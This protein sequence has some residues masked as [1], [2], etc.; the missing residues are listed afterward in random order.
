MGGSDLPRLVHLAGIARASASCASLSAAHSS[1]RAER[2]GAARGSPRAS[3]RR[4]RASGG[5]A[6]DGAYIFALEEVNCHEE[7]LRRHAERTHASM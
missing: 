7:V 2:P 4:G 5:V 1:R 6:H 3:A